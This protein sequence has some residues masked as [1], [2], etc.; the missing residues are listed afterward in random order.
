MV[1]TKANF[2]NNTNNNFN[3]NS[4]S[5]SSRKNRINDNTMITI[6]LKNKNYH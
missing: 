6:N 3:N 5:D 2:N 1:A 4:C